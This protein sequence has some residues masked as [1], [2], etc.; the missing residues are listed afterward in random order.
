MLKKNQQHK[1]IVTEKKAAEETKGGKCGYCSPWKNHLERFEDQNLPPAPGTEKGEIQQSF[2]VLLIGGFCNGEE[3]GF[4]KS[5]LQTERDLPPCRG[6]LS[7]LWQILGDVLVLMER[8]IGA[9]MS[10]EKL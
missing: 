9:K 10:N 6:R 1:N 3:S 5:S 4:N 8:N 7:N 2:I